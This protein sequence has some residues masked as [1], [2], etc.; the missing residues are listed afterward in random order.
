MFFVAYND[1]EYCVCIGDA[2]I[3]C[4]CTYMCLCTVVYVREGGWSIHVHAVHVFV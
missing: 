1:L 4:A 3:Y 2:S